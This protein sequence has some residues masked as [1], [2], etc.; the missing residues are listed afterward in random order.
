MGLWLE[1]DIV[2]DFKGNQTM[3]HYASSW[4]WQSVVNR[5]DVAGAAWR[6]LVEVSNRIS[7][8]HERQAFLDGSLENSRD[9]NQDSSDLGDTQR[10]TVV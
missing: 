2:L 3:L 4:I 10:T 8:L 1:V 7:I 5:D 9:D 6:N